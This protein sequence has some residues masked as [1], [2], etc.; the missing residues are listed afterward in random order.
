MAACVYTNGLVKPC[1]YWRSNIGSLNIHNSNTNNDPRNS[2]EWNKIREDMLTGVPIKGCE[3]CY[4]IESTGGHSGRLAGFD[5]FV[6]T[7]NK[8]SPLEDIEIAF[9][10]LC[11]LACVGCGDLNSTKWSTENI[12]AGRVGQKLI[13]NKFDWTVWDL[14][15]LK[16]LKILGGEPFMEAT[17]F[18]ELL[19][20]LN[21]SEI[22]LMVYTNGTILPSDRLKL[23]IEKCKVVKFIVSIDGFENANNWIRWPSKFNETVE[24]MKTY[25]KWWGDFNNIQLSTNSVVSVYNIFTMEKFLDFMGTDFK[26]WWVTFNWMQWPEWPALKSLPEE[27]KSDLIKSFSNKNVGDLKTYYRDSQ[28]FYKLAIEHLKLPASTNS[29]E[30]VKDKTI[31]LAKERNLDIDTLIP[32]FKKVMDQY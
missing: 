20:Q 24:T 25:Q 7:E 14:S 17:R 12:K 11:N 28:D 21:L 16:R 19:E 2:V 22:D 4:E 26:N 23:L 29:W 30:I 13:D 10:N 9:S 18:C 27:I 3:K 5:W 31:E 8:L 15:K 32:D 6:P 1:C